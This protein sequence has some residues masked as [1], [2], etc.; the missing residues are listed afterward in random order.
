MLKS[1]LVGLLLAIITVGIHAV[2][3]AWWIRRLKRISVSRS[4]TLDG[5]AILKVLA[6]T[7]TLLLVLHIAEVSV[8]AIAYL[9]IPDL[10]QINTVEEAVYFSMVTFTSLG[11]GDLVIA[12]SW[13]ILSGIQAMAG[14]M[15][16][17]WSTAL[18]F[19]VVQ[20]TWG[21]KDKGE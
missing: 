17:G 18:L 21:A 16:F 5:L 15:I 7:V 9:V 2:G 12:G 13:R 4:H 3:T 20:R 8:W 6:S 1:I 11:Y 19:A 10:E 14:L